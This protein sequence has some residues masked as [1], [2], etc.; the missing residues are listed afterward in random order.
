MNYFQA[1]TPTSLNGR[2]EIDSGSLSLKTGQAVCNTNESAT[3]H[4]NQKYELVRHLIRNM[5]MGTSYYKS[6]GLVILWRI[7]DG[8][9]Y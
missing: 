4:C 3:D 1:A 2:Q 6:T 5:A 9:T 8:L 7:V